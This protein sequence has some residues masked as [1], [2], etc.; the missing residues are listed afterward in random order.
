M[1]NLMNLQEVLLQNDGPSTML[2]RQTAP[3]LSYLR[4]GAEDRQI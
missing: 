2:Y 3:I 4:L 1:L